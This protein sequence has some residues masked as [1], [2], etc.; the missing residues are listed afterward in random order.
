MSKSTTYNEQNDPIAET[1]STNTITVQYGRKMGRENYGNEE[2]GIFCQV[3]VLEEDDLSDI[4]QKVRSTFAFAKTLVLSELGVE[5]S[6]TDGGI[7][8][9]VGGSDVA[10][11]PA[12]KPRALPKGDDKVAA[13]QDVIDNPSSWFDNRTDKKNPKG[14][15]FKGKNNG[16]FAGVGLWLSDAPAFA[17]LV[18]DGE[19][20][21]A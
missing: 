13:W 10:A 14:P 5:S 7:V 2:A 19:A 15:D 18:L 21:A 16:Q 3:D 8:R 1:I 6:E 9:D 4:E 20:V 17:K 12:A 11:K